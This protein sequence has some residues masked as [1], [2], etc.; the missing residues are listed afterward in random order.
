MA[1]NL[2]KGLFITFEG[3]E[4]C[5]KSTHS[6]R[7]NKDLVASGYQTVHTAE[8]GGTPLGARIRQVLL[9]EESIGFNPYAELF[10]FEADRAQHIGDVIK[11]ALD[12][13][14]IVICDRF[15]TATFAY[16]GYGLGMDLDTVK[17]VDMLARAG[18][19]PDLTIILD[20]DVK[21]GLERANKDRSADKMERRSIEFHEKVRQ[22]YL[23]MAE[24]DP[25]RIRV[26][27]SEGD[28]DAVY[29]R[30]REE[31]YGFI[32]RDKRAG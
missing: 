10:L 1:E 9:E 14:K 11:P 22:G 6:S 2:K 26:I 3:P 8:P 32:E 30:V 24:Q 27:S 13:R 7:I 19:E 31:V 21:S 18:I 20:I 29:K 16:Q 23:S 12:E 15:S 4:G 25:E 17:E 5:G 28:I